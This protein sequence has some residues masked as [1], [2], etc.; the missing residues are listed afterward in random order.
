[1]AGMEAV[2]PE[3][4]QCLQQENVWDKASMKNTDIEHYDAI[5]PNSSRLYLRSNRLPGGG[6]YST[7]EDMLR[8]GRS[9]LDG[10]SLTKSFTGRRGRLNITVPPDRRQRAETAVGPP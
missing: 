4:A 2:A 8:F 6:V 9:V 5:P 1:M 7:V 10:T 3:A